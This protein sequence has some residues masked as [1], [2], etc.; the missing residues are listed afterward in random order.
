[1]RLRHGEGLGKLG[2]MMRWDATHQIVVNAPYGD[3]LP[4]THD[5]RMYAAARIQDTR[6]SLTLPPL[7]Y[8]HLSTDS[9]DLSIRT[10]LRMEE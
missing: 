6:T 8:H 7:R 4:S 10:I 5:L 2:E 9:A 1:M 3:D